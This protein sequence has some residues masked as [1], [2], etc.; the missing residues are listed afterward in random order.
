[1]D[2]HNEMM[3]ISALQIPE[4]GKKKFNARGNRNKETFVSI[5]SKYD[6]TLD[7]LDR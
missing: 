2:Y 5:H 6:F 7:K 3:D 4:K 1:M